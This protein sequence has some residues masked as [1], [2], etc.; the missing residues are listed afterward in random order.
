MEVKI[1]RGSQIPLHGTAEAAGY[2]IHAA[3]DVAMKPYEIRKIST[4]LRMQMP[5]GTHGMLYGRSSM[6]QRG[7]FVFPAIIDSDY[8]GEVMVQVMNLAGEERIIGKGNRIAQV[9]FEEHK[10]VTFR[11]VDRLDVSERGSGGF[12]STGK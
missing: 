9:I 11:E 7:L 5:P 1:L 10:T 12:G 2:D 4:G 8:R 6:G 3:E